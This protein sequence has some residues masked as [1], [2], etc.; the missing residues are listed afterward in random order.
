[1]FKTLS[2]NRHYVISKKSKER[3]RSDVSSRYGVE[4]NG[5]WDVKQS[6]KSSFVIIMQRQHF[7]GLS[8]EKPFV[9]LVITS[10]WLII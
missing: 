9:D 1:M 8:F 10:A 2:P 5:R 4:N 6:R 3:G 7:F